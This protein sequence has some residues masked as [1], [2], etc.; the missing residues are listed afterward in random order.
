VPCRRFGRDRL[1]QKGER[2]G[3]QLSDIVRL[4][5]TVDVQCP[6][7]V[8]HPD[9]GQ[10]DRHRHLRLHRHPQQPARNTRRLPRK[11]IVSLPAT[12]SEGTS[13]AATT[14]SPARSARRI[15]RGDADTSIGSRSSASATARPLSP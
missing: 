8:A 9:A 7:A 10:E 1:L 3:D 14:G 5:Q 13:I 12:W 15:G 4:P 11:P 6:L 2:A